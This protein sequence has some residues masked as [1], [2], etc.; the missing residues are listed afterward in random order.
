MTNNKFASALRALL[1]DVDDIYEL[2]VNITYKDA[3]KA[4]YKFEVFDE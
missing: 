1:D 3:S 2:D 4:S